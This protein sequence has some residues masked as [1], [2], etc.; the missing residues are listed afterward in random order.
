M[1]QKNK[2]KIYF[3]FWFFKFKS[4]FKDSVFHKNWFLTVK[5][6]I[7][8][9][10]KCKNDLLRLVKSLKKNKISPLSLVFKALL[11]TST[12][13]KLTKLKNKF[14]L[15]LLTINQQVFSGVKLF[16]NSLKDSS[17][18]VRHFSYQLFWGTI[19]MI[20]KRTEFSKV[21]ALN[22]FKVWQIRRS[23]YKKLRFKKSEFPYKKK[24]NIFNRC[25]KQ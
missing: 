15:K 18:F 5:K 16:L 1:L 23:T 13:L 2:T 19:L 24:K 4:Y 25:F 3:N 8:K 10:G 9:K 14:F 20:L 22:Y 7:I 17:N 11:S 21:K 12:I 6:A